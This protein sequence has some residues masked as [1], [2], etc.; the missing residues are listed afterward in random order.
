MGIKQILSPEEKREKRNAYMRDYYA[1][2]ENKLKLKE[3][4]ASPKY[5][6]SNKKWKKSEKGKAYAKRHYER[7]K[8]KYISQSTD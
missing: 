6:A 8:D 2:P 1:K 7:N 3:R 4:N 5:K